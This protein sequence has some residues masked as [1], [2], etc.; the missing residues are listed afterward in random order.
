MLKIN[1][2]SC[3]QNTKK[4]FL[5]PKTIVGNWKKIICEKNIPICCYNNLNILMKNIC[6][7]FNKHN[8]HYWLDWGSLLGLIRE[9][10]LIR[11]DND[12]DF[13]IFI[14]D[15]NKLKKLKEEFAN[16][17]HKLNL[18]SNGFVRIFFSKKN[19]LHADIL[20]WKEINYNYKIRNWIEKESEINK[21][22][23]RFFDILDIIDYEG[24]KIKV[25]NNPKKYLEF[26]YGPKLDNT[27]FVIL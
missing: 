26:R 27:K 18:D 17:G 5:K 20:L 16:Y 3:N 13:G 23:K 7:V 10:K 22:P 1:I 8:F 19:F 24:I 6:E 25:P 14:K 11:Y 2:T 21:T 15:L 12:L 9:G 4:C